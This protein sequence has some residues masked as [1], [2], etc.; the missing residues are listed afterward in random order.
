MR[1][2]GLPLSQG[3]GPQAHG[4]LSRYSLEALCSAGEREGCVATRRIPV[5]QLRIGMF[6][7]KTDR[8]WFWTPFLRR[9][10]LVTTTADVEKLRQGAIREVEIDLA[11]GIDVPTGTVPAAP[12][13]EL[14]PMEQ[15]GS[16]IGP[17]KSLA[18]M[19]KHVQMATVARHKLEQTVH[20]LFDNISATGAV[21][22]DEAHEAAQEITIVTRTLT[23]PALFSVMSKAR[24]TAPQLGSHAMSVCT[25]A[26]I[27]GQAAGLHLV[28][29]QEL[30]IGAL[31]HDLGLLQVPAPMLQRA[32]NSSRPLSDKERKL[33]EG[34][35]K[36]G[37]VDLERQG[38]FA[39]EVRRIVAE[40]HVF[41]NQTGYPS[42]MHPQWISRLSRI[43]MIADQYDEM[44]SGFGGRTPVPPHEALQQ[45]YRMSQEG[46]LDQELTTLFIKR[47]GVFP[48]YSAVELN[49]GER[50][51][52]ADLNP[53]HLHLP[54]IFVTH[55]ADG[56]AL[57]TPIRVDLLQQEPG[58]VVRSIAH[59]L[60]AANPFQELNLA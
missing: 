17:P 41:L 45:L 54:V 51:L 34:H 56:S 36:R 28:A 8:S 50:G 10:F 55:A 3:L 15:S 13:A 25:F 16:L 24:D 53:D 37:A 30:A 32:Y 47:V 57:A 43:V 2:C 22:A 52:I 4:E 7:T 44:I 9:K 42:D 29:L 12:E 49:T 48:I 20:C 38:S 31:L 35:G 27:L 59:V 39:L 5:S 26:M 18:A 46:A 19:A 33:Y 40:H 21:N 1:G 14:T 11:K 60:K 23:N 58:Q 6:V